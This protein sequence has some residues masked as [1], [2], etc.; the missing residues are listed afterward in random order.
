MFKKTLIL[1][2]ALLTVFTAMLPVGASLAL[3]LSV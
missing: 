2:V 1:L 3:P